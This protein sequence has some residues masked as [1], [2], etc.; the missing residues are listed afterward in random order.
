MLPTGD[1]AGENLGA[2]GQVAA[3]DATWS[4]FRAS[5]THPVRICRSVHRNM[6]IARCEVCGKPQGMKQDYVHP[7]ATTEASPV[8]PRILC[9]ATS[10][11]RIAAIWLTDAEEEEYRRGLRSF[12]VLQHQHVQVI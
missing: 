7:H 4:R 2:Y 1:A 10:C 3:H 5:V 12:K 9:G 8:N 11:V 6:A